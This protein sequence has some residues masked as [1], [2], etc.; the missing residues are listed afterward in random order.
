MARCGFPGP[1]PRREPF[2][3]GDKEFIQLVARLFGVLIERMESHEELAEAKNRA[4]EASRIKSE[5]LANISHEIRT[6]LNAIIGFTVLTME[7]N[8]S[9]TQHS[10][11]SKIEGACKKLLDIVNEILDFSKTENGSMEINNVDFE[12]NEILNELQQMISAKARAKGLQLTFDVHQD[13]PIR[14]QGD[15]K[16]LGRVLFN[17]SANAVKFTEKGE[18]VISVTPLQIEERH[19]LLKFTIRDSGIGISHEQQ[20]NLFHSFQQVDGSSTRKFGGT[21]LG[22]AI[23]KKM[24]DLMGGEIGVVSEIGK[25]STFFF[26]IQFARQDVSAGSDYRGDRLIQ[27]TLKQRG[28]HPETDGVLVDMEELGLLVQELKRLLLEDNTEAQA[29]LEKILRISR[30]TIYE[31]VFAAMIQPVRAY[32]YEEALAVLE[33]FW[34]SLQKHQ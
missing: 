33:Q 9:S 22:L 29:V 7:T 32:A 27:P 6:P 2:S 4:E 14:L 24:I 23:S 11:V 28:P 12:L 17:L 10:Y 20:N 26:I 13:V 8:L 21:G 5:F 15:P 1:K 18:I 19:V 3:S 31:N 16:L 30:G 34:T 25:G